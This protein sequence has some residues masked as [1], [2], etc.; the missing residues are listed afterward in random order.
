LL[1]E[2]IVVETH[3]KLNHCGYW[4][5]LSELRKNYY[6][7]S[8]YSV[9]KRT[10]RKCIWCRR[11]NNR[12]IKVNQSDYRDFRLS[13]STI[14]FRTMFIDYLGPY[15]VKLSGVRIK[16]YLLCLTCLWSRA[17]NLQLC[18][19]LSV[20]NFLKAFQLHTMEYGVPERVLSDSGSQLVAAGH[21][22]EDFVRDPDT[23]LYFAN[24]NMKA[25][26]FTTYPKGCNKLGGIVE[27]CVKI[28]KRLIAGAIR[29]NVIDYFD[30][31]FIVSQTIHLANRRPIA[32][33]ESLHDQT[34]Q[35]ELPSVITPEILLKGHE[36]VSLNIIPTLHTDVEEY[37]PEPRNINRAAQC[38]SEC[39]KYLVELFNKEILSNLM[40]HSTDVKE[41]Y[42]HIKHEALQRGDIVLLKEPLLKPVNFP[43][44]IVTEVTV[45]DLGEATA[46]KARKGA[47]GEVVRRHTS[48]IVPLLRKREYDT[49][50]D[51]PPSVETVSRNVSDAAI[52]RLDKP[53]RIAA[54]IAKAKIKSLQE[55]NFV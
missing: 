42:V 22:I 36:L 46:V 26:K 6:I 34:Q 10:L 5:V 35:F 23:Q 29:K 15:T 43:L 44:G 19:D 27:S 18:R 17:L 49:S 13:P 21:S 47:T 24:N 3:T 38:L 40:V 51:P 14:P 45:N 8:C 33:K 4:S 55:L 53:K 32:F 2:R 20:P 28:V 7:P 39:R 50:T 11:F 16:V 25:I 9:V 1:T 37:T 12:S 30:F 31:A 54:K 48:S 41:R 52:D